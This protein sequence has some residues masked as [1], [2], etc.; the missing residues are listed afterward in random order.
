MMM[1]RSWILFDS[2]F[3]QIFHYPSS[4]RQQY[5]APTETNLDT[6]IQ[7]QEYVKKFLSGLCI[8]QYSVYKSNNT[9]RDQI[10]ITKF[11]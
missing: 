1:N 5:T 6:D 3:D 2:K 8:F 7:R 9:L 10:M 4:H 11:Y